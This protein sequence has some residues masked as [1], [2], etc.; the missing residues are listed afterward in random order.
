MQETD[1]LRD[2]ENSLRDFIACVLERK[3][4]SDWINKCGI[5][6]ERIKI[7]KERKEI[8][9]TKFRSGTAEERPIYYADF[10]D[11]KTILQKNWNGE[12]SEALGELKRIEALLSILEGFRDSD[13]HR[14]E[15]LQHQKHLI[16]GISGEIRNL[17]IKYRSKK[18]TGEDY[19]PRIESVIDNLGNTWVAGKGN[20][21]MTKSILRVG[22][23]LE[24]V[25]TGSDPEGLELEYQVEN[26][27][28]QGR[29]IWTKSNNLTVKIEENHIGRQSDF[30]IRIKSPRKYHAQSAW[31][32][33]VDFSYQVLPAK[34]LTL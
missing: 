28:E 19:F 13:A 3:F 6:E 27:N 30:F 18:E 8:E 29:N 9:M 4:A 34:K 32:D 23:T 33:C 7:W 15:L 17:L 21:I 1:A 26:F 2:V 31:D 16:I 20:A 10:Y 5:S 24:F 12:F 11:L 22:D 25:V 14:R